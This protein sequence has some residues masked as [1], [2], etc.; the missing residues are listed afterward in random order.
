M[1]NS[2]GVALL[3]IGIILGPGYYVYGHFFSGKA[4]PIYPLT[5]KHGAE[6]DRFDPLPIELGPDM[7][8]IGL[9]LRFRT[10]HG[11]VTTPTKMPRNQYRATL[12]ADGRTILDKAFTLSSTSVESQALLN[13]SEALPVFQARTKGV[14]H[15][16]IR[17][18]GEAGMNL[19]SAD[20]Q[21]RKD[22]VQPNP[23]LV[24]VG[25]GLL[26]AGVVLM[27]FRTPS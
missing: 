27:L 11:P 7:G 13:F 25:V 17:Q 4:G 8:Q 15:L 18:T 10:E 9:I 24:T 20:V 23:A 26:V 12:K 1:G 19:I 6:G 16:D 22:V 3:V 14:Y 2:A 5:V 21:V